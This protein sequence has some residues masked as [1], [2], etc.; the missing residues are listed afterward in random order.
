MGTKEILIFFEYFLIFQ[1]K[2]SF[3]WNFILKNSKNNNTFC[4]ILNGLSPWLLAENSWFW[5]VDDEL[6]VDDFF[7]YFWNFQKN[8]K[9]WKCILKNSK[10]DKISLVPMIKSG[11]DKRGSVI[12]ASDLDSAV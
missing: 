12:P 3:F 4:H 6:F 8:Q 2:M 1:N 10:N 9:E 11:S 7:D 5:T